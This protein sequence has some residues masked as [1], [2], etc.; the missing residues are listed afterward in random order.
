MNK[1]LFCTDLDNTLFCQVKPDN[2]GICVAMKNGVHASYMTSESYDKFVALTK[3]LHILPVTT[4]CRKS[5]EN[6]YLK[7]YFNRALVDNGAVLVSKNAKE[8]IDW[9]NESYKLIE[10]YEPAF[11]EL[12][13]I[14]E[15]Y[16]YEEKWGSNFV[17][18]YVHKGLTEEKKREISKIL[19]T[20]NKDFLINMGN[21]SM[22]C[23]YK[24][25]SKGENIKRYAKC[26]EY[27]LFMSAGDNLEDVSMYEQTD[28]SIG[29]KA[30]TYILDTND[31]LEFC[32]F[33][34]NTVYDLLS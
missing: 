7:K 9:L 27:N 8:E 23:T 10:K 28:I 24:K 5:Y 14:L 16:G 21:S 1:N 26:Y 20:Y 31:K 11:K 32:N 13:N 12:R 30:A 19:E 33:V 34:I 25:L 29:K 18:D 22:L 2:F 3:M 6:V 4:R 15:S 17:L